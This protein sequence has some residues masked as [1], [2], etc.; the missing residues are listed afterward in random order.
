MKRIIIVIICIMLTGLLYSKEYNK[1]YLSDPGFCEVDD[2]CIYITVKDKYEPF[3][4]FFDKYDFSE[5]FYIVIKLNDGISYYGDCP[6]KDILVF[7]SPVQVIEIEAKELEKIVFKDEKKIEKDDVVE[8]QG[9]EDPKKEDQ[10][11]ESNQPP[12][13]DIIS[14]GN[15]TEVKEDPSDKP[16][17]KSEGIKNEADENDLINNKDNI[18][19]IDKIDNKIIKTNELDIDILFSP[20]NFTPGKDDETGSITFKIE[21]NDEKIK[22][23]DFNI[24]YPKNGIF[25]KING[26]NET[27]PEKIEWNGKGDAGQFFPN[28]ADFYYNLVVIDK[29]NIPVKTKDRVVKTK[30]IVQEKDNETMINLPDLLFETASYRLTDESREIL[31]KV[32]KL[33]KNKKV[34]IIGHTDNTGTKKYNEK[35]SK[36]RATAV[37]NYFIDELNFSI[38]MFEIDGKGEDEPIASN[39]T[40]EGRF[41]N[42]RVEI[43]IRE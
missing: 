10:S 39:D 41:K 43:I 32:S 4:L 30:L 9:D 18:D 42:R 5:Y 3:V 36:N 26:T 29:S 40:P 14:N 2:N 34:A 21:D 15:S 17:D 31:F 1:I 11:I 25:K 27:I 8:D 28:G 37:L 12:K 23:W 19:K 7:R 22:S 13:N 38:A 35:L 6:K 20:T 33:I 24:K 16:I